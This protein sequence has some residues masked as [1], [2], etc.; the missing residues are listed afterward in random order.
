MPFEKGRPKTGGR[1]KG[2]INKTTP[3]IREAIQKVMSNKIDELEADL[4]KIDVFLAYIPSKNARL[5]NNPKY[6]GKASPYASAS[7]DK[8]QQ[9]QLAWAMATKVYKEGFKPRPIKWDEEK[10][11]LRQDLIRNAKGFVIQKLKT[12]IYNQYGDNVKLRVNNYYFSLTCMSMGISFGESLFIFIC[13]FTNS[14]L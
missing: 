9:L 12:E 6:Y 1:V 2:S 11:V 8:Q 7:E 3:E 13:F 5:I 10:E 14:Y 4:E